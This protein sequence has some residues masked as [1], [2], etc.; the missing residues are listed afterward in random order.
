MKRI[1]SRIGRMAILVC[2]GG[3]GA[4][5]L[6]AEWQPGLKVGKVAGNANWKDYPA[7]TNTTLRLDA[8]ETLEKA[9]V[10]SFWA[11]NVTY[12]YWGQMYFKEGVYHF[13]KSLDDS[14]WMAI[15]GKVVLVDT[16][17]SGRKS[18]GDITM[19]EGWHDVEFRFGNGV[20]DAGPYGGAGWTATKGFGY[21]FGG[22]NSINGD[23]YELLFDT[24]DGAFFRYDD[25]TGF[26]NPV[27]GEV[28]ANVIDG[29]RDRLGR[30]RFARQRQRFGGADALLWRCGRRDRRCGVGPRAG[31]ADGDGGGRADGDRHGPGG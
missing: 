30:P 3:L 26:G 4:F 21:N 8:A 22:N 12:V 23:D 6:R 17:W 1:L 14:G 7:E 11:A 20:G 9:N 24:G 25:G 10:Y 2:L 29:A 28:S 31:P 16:T 19:T 27:L 18:S 5:A 13:C 15:D